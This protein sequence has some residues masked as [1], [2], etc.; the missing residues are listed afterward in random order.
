[1]NT[2]IDYS[3][4]N[5]GRVGRLGIGE[6]FIWAGE[7]YQK[8]DQCWVQERNVKGDLEPEWIYKNAIKA[9]NGKH[10]YF[11]EEEKIVP[12]QAQIKVKQ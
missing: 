12:V 11:F 9:D 6:Y 1:M 3:D 8:T 4:F 10:F 2:E 7:L 5:V